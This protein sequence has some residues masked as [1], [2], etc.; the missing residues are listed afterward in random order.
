LFCLLKQIIGRLSAD[1]DYRP[2]IGAPLVH[3]VQ[4]NTN[5]ELNK[6]HQFLPSI[7]KVTWY[8][9]ACG[10]RRRGYFAV[11]DNPHSESLQGPYSRNFPKTSSKDL[12]TSDDLGIPMSFLFRILGGF[13]RVPYEVILFSSL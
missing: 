6:S 8:H 10:H 11:D 2:I 5:S 7:T 9:A 12:P 3:S 1:A 4:F 13:L